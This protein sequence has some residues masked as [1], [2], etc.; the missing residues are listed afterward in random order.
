VDGNEQCSSNVNDASNPQRTKCTSTAKEN[1]TTHI[2]DTGSFCE[3]LNVADTFQKCK[4][5]RVIKFF[6]FL[7]TVY[8]K[9]GSMTNA[10]VYQGFHD[11]KKVEEHWCRWNSR[12]TCF[13]APFRLTGWPYWLTGWPYWHVIFPVFCLLFGWMLFL[14]ESLSSLWK[15]IFLVRIH[16]SAYIINS[17][18]A[19]NCMCSLVSYLFDC[20]P[21]FIKF[22]HHFTRLT[23]KGGLHFSFLYFI[24]RFRWRSVFPWLRFVDRTILS[25]S[26]F[27][28]ITCTSIS[29]GIMINRRQLQWCKH[30]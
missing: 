13:E 30:H 18:L 24:E 3:I 12:H 22:F 15:Y 11:D 9:G 20:K 26:I 27:F 28:S 7:I 14:A 29:G 5:N 4:N 10:K 6:C 16:C 23:I 17:L 25:H 8:V 2:S 1:G 19:A 21:R